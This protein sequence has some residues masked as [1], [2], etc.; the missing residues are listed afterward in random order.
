M[1]TFGLPTFAI[2]LFVAAVSTGT[3]GAPITFCEPIYCRFFGKKM[4]ESYMVIILANAQCGLATQGLQISASGNVHADNPPEPWASHEPLDGFLKTPFDKLYAE[5]LHI[6]VDVYHLAL[7][8]VGT[9]QMILLSR[10]LHALIW[11]QTLQ[12]ESWDQL[13]G[14]RGPYVEGVKFLRDHLEEMVKVPAQYGEE[15]KEVKKLLDFY[16][17]LEE[18]Y[19]SYEKAKSSGQSAHGV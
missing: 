15:I 13:V 17:A 11:R 3:S 18:C 16:D 19:D 8:R 9:R 12:M 4:H 10:D 5:A 2:S 1:K 7:E 6:V 14:Y